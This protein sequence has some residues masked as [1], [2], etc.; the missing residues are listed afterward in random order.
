MVMS[1]EKLTEL[2][3]KRSTRIGGVVLAAAIVF[4]G[5]MWAWKDSQSTIPELVTYVDMAEDVTIEDDEVPLGKAKVTLTVGQSTTLKASGKKATWKS[6]KKSVATVNKKGK[7]TAK[8]E[9]TATITAKVGKK[10]TKWNIAVTKKSKAGTTETVTT[11]A[12]KTA[13]TTEALGSGATGEIPVTAIAARV[14]ARVSNA[15]TTMGCTIKT[16]SGVPYDGQFD[17]RTRSITLNAEKDTSQTVYHELGH[18]LAFIAGNYDKSTEFA[19]IFAKEQS[20]YTAYNKAYV[21]SNA[22]EYFAESFKNYTL[23]P[24]TLQTSRPET[25]AAIVN[26]LAKVTDAQVSAIMTAYSAIWA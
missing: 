21:C 12:E 13:G 6:S 8:K 19:A 24:T 22:S 9:G 2:L 20:L 18:F 15:F 3:K 10:T 17:A 4:S 16:A 26:C 7:V 11:T 25:Y 14:D 5:S 1:R 23:D